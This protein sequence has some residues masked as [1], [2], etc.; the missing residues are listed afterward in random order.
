MG[1]PLDHLQAKFG[2]VMPAQPVSHS[3]LPRTSLWAVILQRDDLLAELN[4]MRVS[5]AALVEALRTIEAL[6]CNKPLCGHFTAEEI[7][8]VVDAALAAATEDQ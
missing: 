2:E 1:A 7:R 8:G 5:H 4:R 3:P 6:I